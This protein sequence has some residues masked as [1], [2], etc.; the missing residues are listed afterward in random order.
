MFYPTRLKKTREETIGTGYK[1][2]KRVALAG[3][4]LAGVIYG[5]VSP[6]A[7]FITLALCAVVQDV[8]TRREDTIDAIYKIRNIT[9]LRLRLLQLSDSEYALENLAKDSEWRGEEVDPEV[10]ARLEEIRKAKEEA[11]A[12]W[13]ELLDQLMKPIAQTNEV[14]PNEE[15][16][17]N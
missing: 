8:L 2:L 10:T 12:R 9:D 1:W 3:M 13:M 14:K 4:I 15:K 11:K 7:G 5:L 17:P 6:I 16:K